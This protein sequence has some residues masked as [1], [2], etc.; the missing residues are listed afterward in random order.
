MLLKNAVT[1]LRITYLQ[2]VK[3]PILALMEELAVKNLR[4]LK[5]LDVNVLQASL[6]Q[7]VKV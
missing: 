7:H 2:F 6:D 3:Q 5:V 4:S 1:S